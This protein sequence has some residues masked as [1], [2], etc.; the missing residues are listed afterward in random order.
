[1]PMTINAPVGVGGKN[2][3]DDVLTVSY[4]AAYP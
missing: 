4:S 1:M 3:A 2:R